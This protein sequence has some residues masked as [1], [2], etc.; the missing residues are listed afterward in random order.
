MGNL[1][2]AVSKD[3]PDPYTGQVRSYFKWSIYGVKTITKGLALKGLIG[4][5]HFRGT[6]PVGNYDPDDRMNG[7]YD[8]HYKLRIMY[9]F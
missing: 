6:D 4:R 9:S 7:P 8:W 5:D 2:D 1:P 3:K